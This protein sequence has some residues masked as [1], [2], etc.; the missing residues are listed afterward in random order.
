MNGRWIARGREILLDPRPRILGIVN[1]TPDSFSDGGL[2]DTPEKAAARA[3]ALVD[4]GADLLDLGGESSRPGAEVVP[5]EEELRR[6][7]PVVEALAASVPVPISVDTCKGSVARRCLEAGAAIINDITS[8]EDPETARAVVEFEAGLVL[9][10]MRGNPRT[11]NQDPRFADVVTEVYDELAERLDRA[12][13]AG[14]PAERIALDPGIGFGKMLDH[15]LLLLRNLGRFATLGRPILIGTSRKGF[16]G[17]LTG[18]D[19]TQR[20]TAS[21]VSALAAATKGAKILRVHDVG[22]LCDAFKVWEAQVG[23]EAT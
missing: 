17:D 10:H 11:M 23:W 8:L 12:I 4:D 9:M 5:A 2:S 15:N 21:V 1:V 16:L 3:R 22:P 19:R 18:R 20:A 14:I 7:L 6:V 13:R